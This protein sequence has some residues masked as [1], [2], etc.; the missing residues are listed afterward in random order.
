MPQTVPLLPASSRQLSGWCDHLSRA[1][2][3]FGAAGFE[4][5]ILTQRYIER[6]RTREDWEHEVSDYVD[7]VMREAIW[8]PRGIWNIQTRASLP[9]DHRSPYIQ[10]LTDAV[11]AKTFPLDPDKFFSNVDPNLVIYH[12][13]AETHMALWRSH[14]AEME[15]VK[16]DEI[17]KFRPL[18]SKISPS[19]T[20]I[21]FENISF[22]LSR[23]ASVLG[24]D[25][26]LIE[27]GRGGGVLLRAS[28][29]PEISCFAE[30]S[31]LSVLKKWGSLQ[32]RFLMQESNLPVK[33]GSE[34]RAWPFGFG[35]N[36][37]MPGG[38]WYSWNNQSWESIVMGLIA[39]V[40]ALSVVAGTDTIISE[41]IPADGLN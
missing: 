29:F 20:T 2:K 33:S 41:L 11:N 5:P 4:L 25:F 26:Q 17:I 18:I 1:R 13:Q 38:E 7:E 6:L 35:L 32:F 39:N 15:R 28:V 30:W 27:V 40:A 10:K 3:L 36:R 21:N 31:D 34:W 16:A 24:L 14:V 23:L 37:V 9:L 22:V 8:L 19:R 12:L